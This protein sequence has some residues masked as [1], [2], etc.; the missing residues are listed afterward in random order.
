MVFLFTR[1]TWGGKKLVE[2]NDNCLNEG[3]YFSAWFG[4]KILILKL[5]LQILLIAGRYMFF[6]IVILYIM[7]L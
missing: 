4:T 1:K 5:E 7:R 6:K 3:E 2:S